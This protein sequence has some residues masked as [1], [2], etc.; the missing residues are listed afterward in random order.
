MGV[1]EVG[2]GVVRGCWRGR[3]GVGLAARCQECG[4]WGGS[5]EGGWVERVAGWCG[6]VVVASRRG[7]A[8]R[9]L[10][11]GYERA[12]VTARSCR[13]AGGRWEGQSA[14]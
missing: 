8:A 1:V 2:A 4:G 10:G 7:R 6:R 5:G 3:G 13:R 12:A 11:L 9:R 14:L